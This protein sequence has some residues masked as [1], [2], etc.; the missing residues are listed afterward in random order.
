M[1]DQAHHPA[2]PAINSAGAAAEQASR[3]CTR[4][5][6]RPP[7]IIPAGAYIAIAHNVYQQGINQR[8]WHGSLDLLERY[9]EIMF[10]TPLALSISTGSA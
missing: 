5:H 4:R 9:R 1:C 3:L 10:L 6:D 7:I 2:N 8:G